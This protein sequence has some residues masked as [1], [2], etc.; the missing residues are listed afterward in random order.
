M[1]RS[2]ET[3]AWIPALPKAHPV[4]PLGGALRERP[5]S[6]YRLV[7]PLTGL[8][9]SALMA[10][11]GSRGSRHDTVAHH[12]VVF[13]CHIVGDRLGS[14][15]KHGRIGSVAPQ[16][17]IVPTSLMGFGDACDGFHGTGVAG[18]TLGLAFGIVGNGFGF[19][20]LG[21]DAGKTQPKEEEQPNGFDEPTKHLSNLSS[22][23]GKPNGRRWRHRPAPQKSIFSVTKLPQ[24]EKYYLTN[25][26]ADRNKQ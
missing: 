5:P 12:A 6:S 14:G 19:R 16:T 22:F 9:R 4:Y 7:A 23:G 17:G 13:P 21:R 1:R 3:H 25:T 26:E 2:A 11:R 20:L 15:L 8:H 10:F 18:Q 24:L